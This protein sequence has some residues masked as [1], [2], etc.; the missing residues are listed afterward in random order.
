MG[1]T[2]K[3]TA[4]RLRP[5][6]RLSLRALL[7]LVTLVCVGL[8]V[9]QRL[10]RQHRLSLVRQWVSQFIDYTS[11]DQQVG[12]ANAQ[13]LPCPFEATPAEQVELLAEAIERFDLPEERTAATKV[14]VEQFPDKMPDVLRELWPRLRHQDSRVLALHLLG[15]A[16]D[17]KSISLASDALADPDPEVRA[18]A[19]DALGLIRQPC[20]LLAT[21]YGHFGSS[22]TDTT[23][24]VYVAT[25][26]AFADL[27]VHGVVPNI[28][29]Q[30]AP[31]P[32]GAGV[33]AKLE[34]MML[35]GESPAER[36]AAARTLFSWQPEEYQLRVAEWGV[37]IDDAGELKMAQSVIDDIPPFVHRTGHRLEDM[38]DYVS[39]I[40]IVTKPVIQVTA[41]RPLAV[42]L[43]VQF[44]RGRPW[45]AYPRPDDFNVRVTT[46]YD[47]SSYAMRGRA[48]P[49]P[50]EEMA[51]LASSG[52]DQLQ[53]SREGYPW[54]TPRHRRVGP[55]ASGMGGYNQIDSV[56]LRWQNVIVSPE[57]LAWMHLP[58]VDRTHHWWSDLRQVPSCWVSSRGE[59]ER[60]LYYDGPSHAKSPLSFTLEA[61]YLFT[62]PRLVFPDDAASRPYA[63]GS[64][65]PV[66]ADEPL[67]PLEA[68]FIRVANG[69]AEAMVI[70]GDSLLTGLALPEALPLEGLQPYQ[71]LFD[72]LVERGL[73][74]GEARGLAD[75]W[76][77][78]FFE[79]DGQRVILFLSSSHY[80]EV[81]PIRVE[82]TPT[83]LVRVGLVLTELD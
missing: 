45:F 20:D 61:S 70:G 21:H 29:K 60:F 1:T 74:V 81:C 24:P 2:D 7:V 42:D 51:K 58:E 63:Q 68:M 71:V 5:R 35:H 31:R 12:F 4:K 65:V 3:P 41:N 33:R 46:A 27:P 47:P 22:Q 66:A 40:M 50:L 26:A 79:T 52:P 72:M 23:P 55:V 8:V 9:G 83:E 13:N 82:P 44:R 48:D 16:R 67:Q 25:L 56:G 69:Q 80:D 49:K 54:L 15:L 11:Q 37:W 59:S 38:R 32:V 57:R 76:R 28:A 43:E 17:D 19:A 10:Y 64:F 53:T 18:A 77:Q 30:V 78:Q 75:C 62:V 73:T 34:R 39:D 36:E 6:L 14:L